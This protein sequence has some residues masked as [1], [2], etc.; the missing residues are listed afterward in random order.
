[1]RG[2]RE[3]ARSTK[4]STACSSLHQFRIR[5]GIAPFPLI[6]QLLSAQRESSFID[7]ST[8][9]LTHPT[10][11]TAESPRRRLWNCLLKRIDRAGAAAQALLPAC[12]GTACLTVVAPAARERAQFMVTRREREAI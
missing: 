5:S 9:K 4:T 12:L 8:D 2:C 6:I 1:M 7:I 10:P 11:T 3:G